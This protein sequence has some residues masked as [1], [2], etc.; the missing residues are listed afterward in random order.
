MVGTVREED[1]NMDGSEGSGNLQK[2]G[3]T[4][5][6]EEDGNRERSGWRIGKK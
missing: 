1:G 5:W 4:T 3:V 2:K 6:R